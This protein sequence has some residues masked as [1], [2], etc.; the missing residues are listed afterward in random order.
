M[1]PLAL[2][3]L[4]PSGILRA[5]QGMQGWNRGRHS[6]KP[7]SGTIDGVL[8]TKLHRGQ[9]TAREGLA[10]MGWNYLVSGFRSFENSKGSMLV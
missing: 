8:S 10:M 4:A 1:K 7:T 9:S 6:P 2:T 3:P 5:P